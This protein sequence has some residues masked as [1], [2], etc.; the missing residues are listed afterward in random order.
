MPKRVVE[1]WRVPVPS[2]RASH[3]GVAAANAAEEAEY[4]LLDVFNSPRNMWVVLD[5]SG[6]EGSYGGIEI[7]TSKGFKRAAPGDWIIRVDGE[8]VPCKPDIF[9]ATYEPA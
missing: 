1:A 6:R 4:M 2:V 7:E 8:W 9:A 3:R 5:A